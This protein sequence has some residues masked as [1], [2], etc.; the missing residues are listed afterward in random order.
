MGQGREKAAGLLAAGGGSSDML[1]N[2]STGTVASATG[3]PADSSLAQPGAPLAR[4]IENES[5]DKV[6]AACWRADSSLAQPG[7]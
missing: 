4:P 7:A 6:S 5:V 3:S 2:M 1:S